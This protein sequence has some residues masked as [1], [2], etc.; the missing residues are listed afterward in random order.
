MSAI[1]ICKNGRVNKSICALRDAVIHS[2]P[3]KKE[4]MLSELE[5]AR[6]EES[7]VSSAMQCNFL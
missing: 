5:T 1:N 2:A 4:I 3:I 6:S 7:I